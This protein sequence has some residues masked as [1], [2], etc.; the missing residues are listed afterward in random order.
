MNKTPDT[1]KEFCIKKGFWKDARAP[2]PAPK[3]TGD[4]GPSVEPKSGRPLT[5]GWPE[6]GVCQGLASASESITQILSA[7]D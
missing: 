6:A 7:I 1:I 3:A 5:S 2:V 4:K